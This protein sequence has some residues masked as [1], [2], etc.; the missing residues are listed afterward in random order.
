MPT[1]KAQVAAAGPNWFHKMDRNRD[2]DIS[3]REFLGPKAAFERLD[4]DHDGLIDAAEAAKA[5]PSALNS[6]RREW[7]SMAVDGRFFEGFHCQAALAKCKANELIRGRHSRNRL[8]ESAGIQ[9]IA[10]TNSAGVRSPPAHR[11][12]LGS[13]LEIPHEHSLTATLRRGRKDTQRVPP[14]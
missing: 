9:W 8:A 7:Q 10:S 5:K 1:T 4:R 13:S 2:G 3:R 12:A 6:G 11:W 14:L